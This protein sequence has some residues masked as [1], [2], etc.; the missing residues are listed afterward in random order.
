MRGSRG[1]RQRCGPNRSSRRSW[2]AS[3]RTVCTPRGGWPRRAVRAARSAPRGP[4]RG[5]L[6]GQRWTDVELQIAEL[7]VTQQRVHAYGQVVA[8]APKS[9]AGCALTCPP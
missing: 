5:E 7:T 8:G 3:R 9:A 4:R 6:A 2:P 1:G